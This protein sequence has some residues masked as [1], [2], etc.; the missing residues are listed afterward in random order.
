[1][2]DDPLARAETR[3]LMRWFNV[4]FFNEA[5][6]WLVREKIPSAS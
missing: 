6:Q 3:R 5:S 2:P 1:M 4:K